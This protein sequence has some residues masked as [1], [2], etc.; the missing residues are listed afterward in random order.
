MA[1]TGYA[2]ILLA[3]DFSPVTQRTARRALDL[4]D[5]Y[6]ARLSMMHVVEYL[7]IALDAELMMP[8][9]AGL[10]E[11]LMETARQHLTQLAESLGLSDATR[12]VEIGSTKLEILRVAEAQGVD[13]IVVGS[14]GRHGLTRMLGS[15]ASAVL[16]GAKCDVLA[17]RTVGG[18]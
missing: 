10:E 18:T 8:P 7:P 17:V 12:F 11:Q 5:R 6:A 2:H 9:V 14:H 1:A 3:V 15:T 13:M 16:Y 4:A